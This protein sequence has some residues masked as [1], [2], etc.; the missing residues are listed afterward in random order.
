[1]FTHV[2]YVTSSINK[3]QDPFNGQS[4]EIVLSL[5]C[6]K[7]ACLR[8]VFYSN[9]FIQILFFHLLI[10]LFKEYQIDRHFVHLNVRSDL[11]FSLFYFILF[12]LKDCLLIFQD[13]Q[14]YQKMIEKDLSNS[15]SI[16]RKNISNAFLVQHL[17]FH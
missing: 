4:A 12:Y 1:M 6:I 11:T 5:V 17:P 9:Y 8:S 13:R 7:L 10:F 3:N 16:F 15:I 2:L 14:Q